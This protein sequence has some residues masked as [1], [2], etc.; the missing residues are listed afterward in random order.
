MNAGVEMLMSA[1]VNNARALFTKSL[2]IKLAF[3]LTQCRQLAQ[4]TMLNVRARTSST[5]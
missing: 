1:R 4:H 2:V 5:R 3:H